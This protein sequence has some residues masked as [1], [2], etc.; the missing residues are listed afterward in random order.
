MSMGL[1]AFARWLQQVCLCF[2]IG[3]PVVIGAIVAP[4]A[5]RHAGLT[6]EQAGNVVGPSLARLNGL[7]YATGA[8]LLLAQLAEMR[9]DLG[10]TSLARRLRWVRFVCAA[11]MFG[12]V[13]WLGLAV[14]PRLLGDR[15]A[16][17][18]GDF[19]IFHQQYGGWTQAQTLLALSVAALTAWLSAL[20]HLTPLRRVEAGPAGSPREGALKDG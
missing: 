10:Q 2:W 19:R 14:M 11:A 4:M 17:R 16:G 9:L 7:L 13:L 12:I 5:F 8:L 20:P 18:M 1:L 3:G 15:A 6:P